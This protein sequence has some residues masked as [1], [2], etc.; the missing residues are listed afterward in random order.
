MTWHLKDDETAIIQQLS[1]ESDRAAVIIAAT[2]LEDRLVVALKAF[3]VDNPKIAD[4]LFTPSGPLG[5]FAVK[6]S[7]GFL[8]GIFGDD[9][10]RELET[11]KNIRNLFAHKITIK[12]FSSQKIKDLTNTLKLNIP[13]AAKFGGNLSSCRSATW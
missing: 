13:G 9:A 7:F 5:S 11:I 3:F 2:I 6:I 4:K 1:E 8:M 10:R 12:D